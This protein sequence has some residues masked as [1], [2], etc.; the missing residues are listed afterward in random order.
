MGKRGM[1]PL[2]QRSKDKDIAPR[3]KDIAP[4]RNLR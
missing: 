4:E 3:R 2:A 1:M